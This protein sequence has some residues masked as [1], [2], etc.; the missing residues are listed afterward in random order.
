M[1]GN[2]TERE[3]TRMVREKLITNC[4]VTVHD[5][6]NANRIFVPDLANLRGK[7]TR[8]K[9]ECMRVEIVQIPQDFV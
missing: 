1:I 4:P 6:N 2:P 3:F 9:P 8:L 5:I 7:M